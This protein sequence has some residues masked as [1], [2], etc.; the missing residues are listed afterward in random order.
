MTRPLWILALGI[1]GVMLLVPPWRLGGPLRE[2]AGYG[3]VFVGAYRFDTADAG[4]I[5]R[6]VTAAHS[7]DVA[8]LLAQVGAVLAFAGAAQLVLARG[9]VSEPSPL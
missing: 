4:A 5:F 1:V 9:R 8:R 7:I 2:S 3:P 6:P